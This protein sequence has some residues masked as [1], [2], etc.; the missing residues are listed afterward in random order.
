[1]LG[2]AAGYL[3]GWATL[4]GT[5]E[6]EIATG[7]SLPWLIDIWL[8]PLAVTSGLVAVLWSTRPNIRIALVSAATSSLMTSGFFVM[9]LRE[10]V[11]PHRQAKR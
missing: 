6:I 8:V 10:L 4:L 9:D 7:W 3:I 11:A 5:L 1:M 2:F